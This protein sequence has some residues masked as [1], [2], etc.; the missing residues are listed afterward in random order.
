[1]KHP[2]DTKIFMCGNEVSDVHGFV[3]DLLNRSQTKVSGSSPTGFFELKITVG[4]KRSANFFIG[5]DSQEPTLFWIYPCEKP[6]VMIPMAYINSKVLFRFSERV[7]E[8]TK[9]KWVDI[10]I[11]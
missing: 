5:Q 4:E 10:H 1:M 9:G 11:P 7:C 8:P 3:G 6:N 2:D